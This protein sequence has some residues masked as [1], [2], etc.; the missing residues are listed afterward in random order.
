MVTPVEG[1]EIPDEL[2][3]PFVDW[4][5]DE[6]KDASGNAHR[7]VN[8]AS[9]VP[10]NGKLNVTNGLKAIWGGYLLLYDANDGS[11][12]TEYQE[13]AFYPGENATIKDNMFSAS[14]GKEFIGW[15]TMADGSGVFYSKDS[16]LPMIENLILYA[17]YRGGSH[18]GGGEG[19]GSHSGGGGGGTINWHSVTPSGSTETNE[20]LGASRGPVGELIDTVTD[21]PIEQ[22][23]GATR[24]AVQTGDSSMML[25]VGLGFMACVAAF[26][27]WE[28]RIFRKKRSE[29]D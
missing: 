10:D 5:I 3:I 28:W 15:N 21:S 22:V 9:P 26:S 13:K 18:S 19:G 1:Q 17:Q 27:A 8:L 2:K 11:G 12:R 7:F 24:K 4:Y 14:S 6:A 16:L 29:A 25:I 20:V 23:L